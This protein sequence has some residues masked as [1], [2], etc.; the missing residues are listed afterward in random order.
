MYYIIPVFIFKSVFFLTHLL[1]GQLCLSPYTF[2]SSRS[3]FLHP[4]QKPLEQRKEM[5]FERR[6]ANITV[7]VVRGLYCPSLKI[8]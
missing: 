1:G 3:C 8:L 6:L 5:T 7:P 2:L 4:S